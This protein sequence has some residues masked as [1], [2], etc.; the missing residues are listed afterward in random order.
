[1]IDKSTAISYIRH[2]KMLVPVVQAQA[3]RE[4]ERDTLGDSS[5][6]RTGRYA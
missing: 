4:L 6:S 1:M 2:G 3:T 5:S